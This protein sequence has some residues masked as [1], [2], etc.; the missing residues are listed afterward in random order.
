[1]CSDAL[2]P[3]GEVQ[4]CSVGCILGMREIPHFAFIVAASSYM[5]FVELYNCY[6]KLGCCGCGGISKAEGVKRPRSYFAFMSKSLFVIFFACKKIASSRRIGVR[7]G[8][9]YLSCLSV[10]QC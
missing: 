9:H 5:G 3:G 6:F 4:I 10:Y 2:N 7:T 8:C 1:M